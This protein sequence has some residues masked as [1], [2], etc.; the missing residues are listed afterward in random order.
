MP[1]APLPRD[2]LVSASRTAPSRAGRGLATSPCGNYMVRRRLLGHFARR[3]GFLAFPAPALRVDRRMPNPGAGRD[4]KSGSDL[5]FSLW[6]SILP[7]AYSS[8]F[9][10]D[11]RQLKESGLGLFVPSYSALSEIL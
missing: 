4:R 9:L 11:S 3:H 8:R 1:N 6:P 10:P 5:R 2:D 7:S